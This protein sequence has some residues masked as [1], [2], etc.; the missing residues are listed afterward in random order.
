MLN[1]LCNVLQLIGGII[2]C[3][4][5]VPQIIQTVKTKSTQDLNLQMFVM[6]FFGVLLMEIYAI[7]L[8]I[9][10]SGVMFLITNSMSLILDFIMI[11]LIKTY[12]NK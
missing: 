2:L 8:V 3:A 5:Y 4:G 10:N 7:N 9:N 6:I 1:I 12:K 11:V